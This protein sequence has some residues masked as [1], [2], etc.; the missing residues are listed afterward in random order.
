MVFAAGS[1]FD[2]LYNFFGAILAFFYGIIPNLG[3][4]DH[5]AHGRRDA[6]AVPAHRQAGQGDDAHAAGAAGDQE[7]PGEVQGRQRKLN[8]EVMKFYQENKI[9]PLA[10]CL[11]LLVQMP[12]FLALFRVHARALQAHPEELRRSTRRSARRAD[13]VVHVKAV[14]R[15]EARHSRTRSTS[16]GWT[17]RRARPASRG[18]FLDALPY[19]ILVGLV[20]VTGVPAVAPEP[21]QRAEHDVADGDDQQGPADRFGFFSLQFPA[22]LVLYFLVSNLWRL[23]QQELIMRK[24]TGPIKAQGPIDVKGAEKPQGAIEVAKAA[25]DRPKA[26][27]GLRKLFQPARRPAIEPAPNGDVAEPSGNGAA[28]QSPAPNAK[29]KPTP[30]PPR[31]RAA[32]ASRRAGGTSRKQSSAQQA[33]APQDQQAPKAAVAVQVSPHSR[34]GKSQPAP[35]VHESRRDA[36]D[37]GVGGDD[38][39]DGRGGARR[40]PRRARASTRTRSSTRWSSSPGPGCS[41]GSAASGARIRARVKPISREKPG[42]RQRRNAAGR[43]RPGAVVV[44]STEPVAVGERRDGA[45]TPSGG[46]TSAGAGSTP[47][48]QGRSRAGGRAAVRIGQLAPA[49]ASGR[50]GL[51]E[52]GLERRRAPSPHADPMRAH[53]RQPRRDEGE[54][55]G[56][57]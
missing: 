35:S 57:D 5:P 25:A 39:P 20:I 11:P 13:G 7:A 43:L 26:A 32:R 53:E 37:D 21:A 45:G 47:Q 55:G 10:G 56:N 42:E 34:P 8:E 18:G 33:A 24:I 12:I 29:P 15:A 36:F 22:G 46:E 30:S 31:P 9:N 17:S 40:R 50:A 28:K 38:R 19:F 4:R 44:G 23:G 6:G 14:Q 27:G 3:R 52:R 1:I 48:G 16:S 54:R 51:A 2:P 41:A 49:R